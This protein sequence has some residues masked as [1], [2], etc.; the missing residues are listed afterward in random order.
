MT[1]ILESRSVCR[2]FGRHRAVDR[3]S[4]SVSAGER[5]ALL[6]HNGAGKTT[7]FKMIL[8]FLRPT[9]GTLMVAGHPPG[10]AAARRAVSYLPENVAFQ[11]SL[12]GR[13]II[14][15]YAKLKRAD[16]AAAEALLDRVGLGVAADRRVGT[17]SKGMRQRLGLAQAL[18]GAPRLLLLDEPTSGL[19]PISRQEFYEIVTE[20]AARGTA[21]FLS[22]HSLT[23]LEAK[24][25]R[26]AIMRSGRLVA[27]A[28]L[29]KLRAE[30]GLPIRI[31]VEATSAD[32]DALAKQLGGSRVN[33]CAVEILC[34]ADRKVERLNAIGA[35]GAAITDIDV[36]P[37]SLDDVYRHF[38][39]ET[40]QGDQS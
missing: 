27:D 4:L 28:P 36:T 17:Y 33:G 32:T 26:V 40:D 2:D 13:E 29:A 8:G 30:A 15:F 3:V 21:V 35:L 16:R 19:D 23:E 6:G 22:S 5:V 10:S 12:T 24:T 11:K 34:S 37:P 14:R 18:I 7:L 25:D 20:I 31:R 9:E 1:A 39:G 38:S